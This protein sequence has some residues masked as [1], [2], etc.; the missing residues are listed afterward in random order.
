MKQFILISS[1]MIIFTGCGIKEYQLFN[2][3]DPSY[4]SQAEDINISYESRIMP[5]D[6]L[7]IDTYNMSQKSNILKD[8]ALLSSDKDSNKF[9]VSED[10]T[11]YLPLLQEVRVQGATVK[12]LSKRLTT[13]YK[14][15][16]K[17]PYT[18]VSIKNHKVFVL[19]EVKKQGIVPI[20]GN[21]ISVIEAISSSGGLTDHASR[22]KI[23]VISKEGGK[24]KIRTLD[25]S[26]LSTL[27]IDNLILKHNTIV[28]IEPRG[29]KA[30]KVGV[31]DYLPIIQVISGLAS[32]F[33]AI[34][35]ISN[36]R[37]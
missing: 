6:I 21:S 34:D 18:K 2:N 7:M 12:E 35:Y 1:I 4:I 17:Q 11:I 3:E 24:H 13:N 29:S 9:I 25:M 27:N 19:G 37:Y 15:Y 33:L 23:R 16:L 10:G 31:Q 30:L 5:D 32:T 28:Y 26:K 36:G 22:D 20:E 8:T 14:K